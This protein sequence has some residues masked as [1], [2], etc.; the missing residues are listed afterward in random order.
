MSVSGRASAGR[1]RSEKLGVL[2]GVPAFLSSVGL[3]LFFFFFSS[4]PDFSCFIR[5]ALRQYRTRRVGC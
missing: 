5:S 1:R 2:G 4:S 3:L